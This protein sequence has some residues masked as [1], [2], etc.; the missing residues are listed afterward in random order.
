MSFRLSGV[1]LIM[2][3]IVLIEGNLEKVGKKKKRQVAHDP[4]LVSSLVSS[5]FGPFSCASSAYYK[6]YRLR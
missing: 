2:R 3:A 4:C 6:S 5:H 1:S